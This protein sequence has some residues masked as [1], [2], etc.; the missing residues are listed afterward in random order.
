MSWGKLLEEKAALATAI[1]LVGDKWSLLI[2]SG[3]YSGVCRFNQFESFLGINRNLLSARLEKLIDAGLLSRH[4]YHEKPPR[5]EYQLTDIAQDLRPVIVGLAAWGERHYSKD[6]A[7]FS[8]VHKKCEH[9]VGVTIHC[10]HCNVH[11]LNDDVATRINANASNESIRVYENMAST[12]K[13]S[14]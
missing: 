6:D 5:F 3:C 8:I 4:Q 14:D 11:V 2:L 7:P 1:E 10:P 12:A 13:I 9:R